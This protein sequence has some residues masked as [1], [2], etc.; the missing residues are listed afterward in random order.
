MKLIRVKDD[1]EMSAAVCDRLVC[2]LK[3]KPTALFCIATGGSPTGAYAAFVK[4]VQEEKLDTSQMKILKLD[5]WCGLE[6]ENPATCESYIQTHLLRP[7]QIGEDRYISFDPLETNADSECRRISDLIAE[8]GNIDCCILGIGKNGHLGLN[9]PGKTINPFTRK[10]TLDARTKT[11]AMLKEN[12]SE[13]TQGYTLGLKELLASE[14]IL[15]LISGAEKE[16]ACRAFLRQE[17]NTEIPA[18][19]L[20]LHGNTTAFLNQE[21]LEI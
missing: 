9:E 15:F 14:E 8:T 5:E 17:I 13:A 1:A 2:C 19:F 10:V 3:K 6:K 4:R 21:D 11:H 16:D 12:K 18:T 7:L 20:W